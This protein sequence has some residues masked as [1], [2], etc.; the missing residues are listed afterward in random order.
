M[1][2]RSSGSAFQLVGTLGKLEKPAKKLTIDMP[3]NGAPVDGNQPAHL[4]VQFGADE[5]KGAFTVP[6]G[7]T[8][9]AGPWKLTVF[10]LPQAMLTGREQRPVPVATLAKNDREGFNLV[11]G[12]SEARLM[13]WPR[14]GGRGGAP[15]A[16]KAEPVAVGKVEPL[17]IKVATEKVVAELTTS[18]FAKGTLTF[19]V[20]FGKEIGRAHV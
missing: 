20:A 6:G 16:A 18:S 12:G 4:V 13:A 14:T 5:W 10:S 17:E 8:V 19:E 9:T 2:F 15:G 11:L 1:L 3:K 7:K